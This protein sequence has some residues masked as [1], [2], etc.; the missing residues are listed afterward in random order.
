LASGGKGIETGSGFLLEG[1]SVSYLYMITL[2]GAVGG[3]MFGYDTAVISG[4]IVFMKEQFSLSPLMEGWVVS[5]ALIG[6][7]AG[8]SFAG[9]LSDRYGRKRGLLLAALIFTIS[10]VGTAIPRTITEF[11]AARFLSGVAVGLASMLSPVYIAEI[12]PAHIRGRLVAINQLAIIFGMLVTYVVNWMLVDIGPT[13]WRWMFASAAVPSAVFFIALLFVPETPRWLVKQGRFDEGESVLARIGG[14]HHA[15]EEI[16][17]IRETISQESG[18]VSQLFQP[19]LRTALIIGI[20]LAVITQVTGINTILYYAPKVFIMAGLAD[21]GAAFVATIAV[22]VV[23][24]LFSILAVMYI[25]RLGRKGLLTIAVTCMGIFLILLG[26]TFTIPGLPPVFTVL[27]VIF[28]VAFF[29]FGLGPGFW[30]LVSEIF[31]T[32]IRGRAMSIVTVVL[33][34]ATFI[35]SVTFPLL[36]ASFGEAATFWLYA[37]MCILAL[38]FIRKVVPETKGKTLEEIELLWKS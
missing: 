2:V 30:V 24:V 21:A 11:I 6:C 32:R 9:I 23:D 36:V 27:S 1:G 5:C 34:S 10:S 12:A 15:K 20:V 8:V 19:G 26:L 35:V 25:D 37:S 22:G 29:M 14:M 17:S 7:I 4:A 16:R 3:L 28:Y 18:S 38:I 13:N 33:W 31:P